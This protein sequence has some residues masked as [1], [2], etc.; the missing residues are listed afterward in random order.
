MKRIVIL[1]MVLFALL[2]TCSGPRHTSP[3]AWGAI[4]GVVRDITTSAPLPF[5][6]VKLVSMMSLR[7]FAQEDGRFVIPRPPGDYS[8]RIMREGYEHSNIV[9]LTVSPSETTEVAFDLWPIYNQPQLPRE[10]PEP[11]H[12]VNPGGL[13]KR[14]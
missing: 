4:S 12:V 9:P 3:H 11:G 14:D 2:V 10:L 6:E 8:I 13:H 5:A 1:C 7:S